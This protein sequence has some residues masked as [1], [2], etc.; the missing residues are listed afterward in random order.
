MN[1]CPTQ[2]CDSK[3]R[4]ALPHDKMSCLC[5]CWRRPKSPE[6]EGRRS[7]S[8]ASPL[9]RTASAAP[10]RPDSAGAAPVNL[11]VQTLTGAKEQVHVRL[12]ETIPSLRAQLAAN[13]PGVDA[14]G[15]RFIYDGVSMDDPQRTLM[16]YGVVAGGTVYMINPLRK[17]L[18]R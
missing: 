1:F 18:A 11:V 5:P 14:E 16:S 4:F 9:Q 10:V 8:E 17:D 6:E 2:L 13:A 12:T 7:P 3:E 15:C